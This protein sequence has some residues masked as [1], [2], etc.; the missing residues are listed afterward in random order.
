MPELEELYSDIKDRLYG[1]IMKLSSS[2]HIAEEIVQETFCRALEQLLIDKRELSYAWFYTVARHLFF[3]YIK[4][5]NKYKYTEDLE[6]DMEDSTNSPDS[7][8]IKSDEASDVKRVLSKL[9]D[10]YRQ[11]LELREFKEL[12]YDEISRM[13]GMSREQVKV[14]L[15]RARSKFRELYKSEL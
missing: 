12:S 8:L 10:S 7:G 13:T 2:R 5:Q 4:K 3:D 15:Y 11:I 1:Y 6:N 14:T 9:N